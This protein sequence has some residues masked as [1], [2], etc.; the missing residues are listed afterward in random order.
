MQSERYDAN[1]LVLYTS[2][3]S[4][5]K[6]LTAIFDFE[7]GSQLEY[8][9]DDSSETTFAFTEGRKSTEV[10]LPSG[11]YSAYGS[12]RHKMYIFVYD[13]I[14]P[15][16]DALRSIELSVDGEE[17]AACVPAAGTSARAQVPPPPVLSPDQ[18]QFQEWKDTL[19]AAPGF[20]D[21][22]FNEDDL[23]AVYDYGKSLCKDLRAG[24]QEAVGFH[25]AQSAAQVLHDGW[26]VGKE[27]EEGSEKA[28]VAENAHIPVLC[29]DQQP[30]LDDAKNSNFVR[31]IPT[32][33]NDGKHLIGER[34]A[35]GTYTVKEPVEDCYWERSDSQGNIIANN[36][37][38]IA[39]SITVTI[40]PTDAGFT[41][42]GCGSWHKVG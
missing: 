10:D 23:K 26:G 30:A 15:K 38:S 18:I 35:P 1:E 21:Y 20:D 37:V 25:P 17:W 28:F 31:G 34:L 6:S 8:S 32:G 12:T 16:E 42:R 11:V 3:R 19:L 9:L 24:G 36:F 14:V 39:P 29:P 5:D 33:F 41:S 2:H 22:S 40:A 4:F 27:G 13:E 7:S